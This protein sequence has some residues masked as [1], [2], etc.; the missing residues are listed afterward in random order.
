MV[1]HYGFVRWDLWDAWIADPTTNSPQANPD[2]W[3]TYL[4]CD[5]ASDHPS[6][7]WPASGDPGA[8][9]NFT[10]NVNRYDGSFEFPEEFGG[11]Q[12]FPNYIT[13]GAPDSYN[14]TGTGTVLTEDWTEGDDTYTTTRTLSNEYTLDDVWDDLA[15]ILALVPWSSMPPITDYYEYFLA[16]R[17]ADNS[18]SSIQ[19]LSP[20]LWSVG[21]P[22][23]PLG[24]STTTDDTRLI[25][26]QQ[27]LFS[28]S[29]AFFGPVEWWGCPLIGTPTNPEVFHPGGFKG[30]NT[31]AR[32]TEG[33][34][35]MPRKYRVRLNNTTQD[36]GIFDLSAAP[37]YQKDFPD[38]IDDIDCTDGSGNCKFGNFTITAPTRAEVSD[39]TRGFNILQRY[40]SCP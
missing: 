10:M 9:P 12:P 21:P 34:F 39:A 16:W 37:I 19:Q 8:D 30:I 29:G 11:F 15:A 5:F 38:P 35:Y 31:S 17:F 22:W 20:Q 1:G 4:T 18:G 28:W 13:H 24:W 32:M 36:G 2:L 27:R 40:Q 14:I 25:G 26:Y 33:R 6:G 3:K 7:Y 23:L